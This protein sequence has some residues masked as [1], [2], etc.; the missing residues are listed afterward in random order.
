MLGGSMYPWVEPV[1]ARV[2]GVLLPTLP[3]DV[4]VAYTQPPAWIAIG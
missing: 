4:H 3:R 1:W 2:G